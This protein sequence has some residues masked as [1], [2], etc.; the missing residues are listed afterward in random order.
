MN[1]LPILPVDWTPYLESANQSFTLSVVIIYNDM[2]AAV[3][4]GHLLERFG[5]KFHGRM[6]P[7]IQAMQLDQLHDQGIYNKALKNAASADMII[8]SVSGPDSFPGA[9]KQW[10]Q[11]CTAQQREGDAAVVAL[12]G[13]TEQVEAPSS[14]RLQY[15]KNAARASGLE[16]YAPRTTD[17]ADA[18]FHSFAVMA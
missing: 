4:A 18:V 17:N 5:R 1:S 15:L 12:L 8:V 7:R 16:F 13:S 14:P 9:L 10:V 2:H 6:E 11:D 3:R